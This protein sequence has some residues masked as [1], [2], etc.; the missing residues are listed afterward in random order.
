MARIRS[1]HPALFSDEGW[2]SCGAWA[3]LLFIGLW[4]DAD[5]RG[6]FEWRPL[7][8]KMR[9]LPGDN[10][11]VE[12][13][14]DELAAAGMVRSF[15]EAGK[16]YGAVKDF[17]KY[18]RP[19]KPR[20]Q[21]PLPDSLVPFVTGNADEQPDL[22]GSNSNTGT[23]ESNQMERRG[24]EDGEKVERKGRGRPRGAPDT[25]IPEGFPD[26]EAITLARDRFA[27]AS[28]SLNPTR[29][30]QRFRDHNLAKGKLFKDWRAAW[31]TWVNNAIAW[32]PEDAKV[33]PISP[34]DPELEKSIY[35]RL[36]KYF[37][38]GDPWNREARGPRPDEPGCRIP[39]EIMAEFSYVPGQ[40]AVAR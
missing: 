40:K 21:F 15:T 20:A 5:D 35:R 33:V 30:A 25:P 22:F 36:M 11:E 32:A 4:T 3:R 18:Q 16:T 19:Q 31:R 12:P 6:V 27:E 13:I 2:V 28:V 34:A 7:Q 14:L 37:L 26:E 1:V 10:I 24:E 17:Q 9:L 39:P 38:D 23:V 8:I 29:E